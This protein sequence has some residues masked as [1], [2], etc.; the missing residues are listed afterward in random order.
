MMKGRWIGK[1][2]NKA[3]V[4]VTHLYAQREAPHGAPHCSCHHNISHPLCSL[5]LF[6]LSSFFFAFPSRHCFVIFSP[7]F[8]SLYF[9]DMRTHTTRSLGCIRL[10]TGGVPTHPRSDF[11]HSVRRSLTVP[12]IG[13]PVLRRDITRNRNIT[14]SSYSVCSGSNW[15]RSHKIIKYSNPLW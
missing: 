7:L 15:I 3:K 2:G 5:L 4:H 14:F 8:H 12:P 10:L 1:R 11:G 9:C 6:L 13:P